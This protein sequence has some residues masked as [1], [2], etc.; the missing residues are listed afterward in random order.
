[1]LPW[2]KLI[3]PVVEHVAR[4]L[5]DHSTR[6]RQLP[7]PLTQ[8]N[9]SAGRKGQRRA[10]P[11]LAQ[12]PF[13]HVASACHGC[14]V[15]LRNRRYK[16]CDDCRPERNREVV[17]EF[18]KAG[19]AALARRRAEGC[20]PTATI[21]ARVRLGASNARRGNE[22]AE[23]ERKHP[24]WQLDT[25][26]FVKEILPR[27]QGVPVRVLADASGLSIGHVARVRRG[28]RVPHPMHWDALTAA[29]DRYAGARRT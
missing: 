17:A 9:R 6:V 23:W 20:D 2:S 16:W 28:L 24:G 25:E 14:G 5:A 18:S 7:T 21:E 10:T 27:L 3:A 13:P 19:P 29:A 1:L 4:N 26:R 12:P 8:A 22:R 15:L 11:P